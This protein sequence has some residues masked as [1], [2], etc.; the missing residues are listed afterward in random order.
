MN[1]SPRLRVVYLIA[2]AVGVFFVRSVG[3]VAAI[4]GFQLFLWGIARYPA[5]QIVRLGTKLFWFFFFVVLSFAFFPEEGSDPLWR[6]IPFAAWNIK[7]SMAG[8][9]E[10]ARMCLRVYTA[11]LTSLLVRRALTS[12]QFVEGLR[13]VF[14]PKMVALSLDA[15]LHM[16]EPGSM[17]GRLDGG[18]GG[19]DGSGGGKK[20]GGGMPMRD[21]LRGDVRY[22]LRK[23]EDGLSQGRRYAETHHEGLTPE[24]SQDLGVLSGLALVAM[25]LKVLK[26]LP[27]LPFAPGHKTILLLPLYIL[28]AELTKTRWGGTILGVCIGVLGFLMGDGRYGIFE[29]LKHVAPGIITDL[30]H[31]FFRADR[32]SRIPGPVRFGILGMIAALGR[33][34]TIVSVTLLI[35]APSAFYAIASPLALVHLAFGAASGAVTYG[36]VRSLEKLKGA[37]GLEAGGPPA[38]VG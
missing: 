35:G 7:I 1:L 10:G 3:G 13:G 8:L 32:P 19:G 17:D 6:Q 26:V 11:I 4:L 20:K 23:I 25:S 14:L 24:Q 22:F 5:Q 28:A 31:P 21:L 29:V 38:G 30:V 36:V 9:T 2:V 18:G 16:V 33:F 34:A 15:A 12:A 37:A 27:G